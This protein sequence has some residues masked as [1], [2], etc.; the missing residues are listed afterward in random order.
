MVYDPVHELLTE[1]EELFEEKRFKDA[2]E[3]FDEV[4]ELD[5]DHEEG[6]FNR[7]LCLYKIKLFDD[8]I[9]CFK[10][11]IDINP[12][13]EPGWNNYGLVLL[14]DGQYQEALNSFDKVTDINPN[15][16]DAWFNKGS[17]LAKVKKYEDA[18]ECYDK[19]L[20][21]D[22]DDDGAYRNRKQAELKLKRSRKLEREK[23]AIIRTQKGLEGR[24]GERRIEDA[25]EWLEVGTDYFENGNYEKAIRFFKKALDMDEEN[26]DAWVMY[27][28]ALVETQEYQDAM[29]CFDRATDIDPDN[30]KAWY[31]KAELLVRF[32]KFKDALLCYDEVLDIDPDDEDAYYRREEIE[33]ELNRKEEL[34]Y[35]K[36]VPLDDK[37]PEARSSDYGLEVF[38]MADYTEDG[39]VV[40]DTEWVDRGAKFV[41][42]NDYHRALECFNKALEVNPDNIE[43]LFA[44]GNSLV[45]LHQA[46]QAIKYYNE[47]LRM[48]HHNITL[49]CSQWA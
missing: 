30:T 20:D 12:K 6:W 15:N 32:K 34:K 24:R 7:G 42:D 27:G 26:K 9:E 48:R 16:I 18:V 36:V 2:I 23:E 37:K 47:A 11:V 10:E 38:R 40:P 49:C 22:P 46:D 33:E 44:M 39:R 35:S 28:I 17:L 13:S 3:K 31:N 29:D 4:L 21:I 19:V 1:G 41:M 43:A 25:D 45:K 14:E 8:A 5:P